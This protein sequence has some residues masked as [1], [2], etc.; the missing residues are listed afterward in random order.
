MT[1]KH[2]V[3]HGTKKDQYKFI[4]K[5]M[6][7]LKYSP[8]FQ[9]L[10]DDIIHFI[11]EHKH[12]HFGK[13]LF[14]IE[15]VHRYGTNDC[16]FAVCKSDIKWTKYALNQ[17]GISFVDFDHYETVKKFNEYALALPIRIDGYSAAT[18]FD[19]GT[20][21]IRRRSA[22]KLELAYRSTK[23]HERFKGTRIVTKI[24]GRSTDVHA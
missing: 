2:V 23:P 13:M 1:A 4:N 18:T 7:F 6:Y 14:R 8:A 21:S 12:Y 17:H 24:N 10:S 19:S 5:N 9:V 22:Q 16:D 3:C 15:T 20:G 11:F